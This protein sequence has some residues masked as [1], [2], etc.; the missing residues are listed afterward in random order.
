MLMCKLCR[1]RMGLEIV[2]FLPVDTISPPL[3]SS[4][5]IDIALADTIYHP[6]AL[7]NSHSNSMISNIIFLLYR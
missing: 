2:S 4:T 5:T 6:G 3:S 1:Q 7:F